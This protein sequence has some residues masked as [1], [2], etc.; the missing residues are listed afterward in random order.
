MRGQHGRCFR[1]R[2]AG[3]GL[4]A[5]ENPGATEENSD[6]FLC[7]TKTK[8]N[9]NKSP[10]VCM[11]KIR[12]IKI[13]INQTKIFEIFAVC[14]RSLIHKK[15]SESW[16]TKV[17]ASPRRTSK[18]SRLT[19]TRDVQAGATPGTPS[20]F[21]QLSRNAEARPRALPVTLWGDR[22]PGMGRGGRS[23]GAGGRPATLLC[24]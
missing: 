8:T 23:R 11:E 4:A 24:S 9:R 18:V 12:K 16:G 5:R 21:Y 7:K 17:Q 14:E 2:G 22:Q 1:K 3:T 10:S 20:L 19:R 6:K 13:Q 15:S